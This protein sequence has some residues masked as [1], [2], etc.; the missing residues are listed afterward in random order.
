MQPLFYPARRVFSFSLT[1]NS[2]TVLCRNKTSRKTT[3]EF[4]DRD[5]FILSIFRHV[6]INCTLMDC[7]IRSYFHGMMLRLVRGKEVIKHGGFPFTM[8]IQPTLS[9]QC[10]A[11]CL[12]C[13]FC[14]SFDFC[15]DSF[16]CS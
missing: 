9:C 5:V 8:I 6:E 10:E 1:K 15:L 3:S 11:N 12:D 4:A 14:L 13:A 7:I 2:N 16:F